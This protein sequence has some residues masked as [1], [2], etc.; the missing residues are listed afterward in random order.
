MMPYLQ[1]RM[2]LLILKKEIILRTL[3]LT[4]WKLYVLQFLNLINV[5]FCD[6][7]TLLSLFPPTTNYIQLHIRYKTILLDFRTKAFMH[8]LVVCVSVVVSQGV[9]SLSEAQTHIRCSQ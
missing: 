8:L 5:D 4:Q 1:K 9:C 6:F 2:K 3:Y 7:K